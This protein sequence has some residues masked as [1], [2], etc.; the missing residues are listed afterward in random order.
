MYNLT[1][2]LSNQYYYS[3][4]QMAFL[5]HSMSFRTFAKGHYILYSV[6]DY[7][8]YDVSLDYLY[9]ARFLCRKKR[10]VEEKSQ[11]TFWEVGD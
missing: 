1:N 4:R 5:L 7:R 9:F 2:I 6:D 11:A 10:S 8:F 3:H